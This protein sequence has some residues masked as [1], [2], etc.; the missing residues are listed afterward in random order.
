VDRRYEL[1]GLRRSLI[2][3]SPGAAGLT[4]E[5]AIRLVD[6]LCDMEE[7]LDRLVAG[8]RHL[9]DQA[10]LHAADA[11]ENRRRSGPDRP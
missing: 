10:D 3:L 8:L 7:R 9:L 5:E 2:M 6:E 1:D 11:V 4:R